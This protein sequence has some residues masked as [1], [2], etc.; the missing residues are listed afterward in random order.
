MPQ[1]TNAAVLTKSFLWGLDLSGTADQAGGIGGLLAISQ[2]ST[3]GLATHLPCFD[4]NGNVMALVNAGSGQPSARYEYAP[5]GEPLRVTGDAALLNPFRFS[6]KYTDDET[7]LLYYGYRYYSPTQAKWLNRDPLQEEGGINLYAFCL[8]NPVNSFDPLGLNNLTEEQAVQAEGAGIGAEGA[9]SASRIYTKLKSY[10]GDLQ[11]FEHFKAGI[12]E[13]DDNIFVDL[14]SEINELQH[15]VASTTHGPL[16]GRGRDHHLTPKAQG[17]SQFFALSRTNPHDLST[18]IPNWQH[19]AVHSNGRDGTGGAWN[20][21]WENAR[22]K[23]NSGDNNWKNKSFVAGFAVG[24][25]L[26][27][28]LG[29]DNIRPYPGKK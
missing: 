16:D 13:A 9:G 28:G 15:S 2:H 6:T 20:R 7:G 4:G 12:L 19:G 25:A 8:N 18:N 29:I 1:G 24:V 5:F 23:A 27:V 3:N 11:D 21:I 26:K 14:I 10:L 22:D 17:L